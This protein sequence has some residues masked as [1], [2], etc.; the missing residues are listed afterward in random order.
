MGTSGPVGDSPRPDVRRDWM[1]TCRTD[2]GPGRR[3]NRVWKEAR[4]WTFH[5]RFPCGG[6][7]GVA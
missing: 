1:D 6:V 4:Q 7:P 5:R 2:M 3:G